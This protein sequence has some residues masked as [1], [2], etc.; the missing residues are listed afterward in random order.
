MTLKYSF[1]NS[2]FTLKAHMCFYILCPST[3]VCFSAKCFSSK[4]LHNRD[5]AE[6]YT[7]LASRPQV[8]SCVAQGSGSGSRDDGPIVCSLRSGRGSAGLHGLLLLTLRASLLTLAQRPWLP[9]GPISPRTDGARGGPSHEP[10][11]LTPGPLSRPSLRPL[12]LLLTPSL[13]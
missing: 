2:S 11:G 3:H 8:G 10:R 5:I 13:A 6:G 1:A 12:Q 7:L 4:S 9:P